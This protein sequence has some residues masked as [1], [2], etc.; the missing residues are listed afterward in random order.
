LARFD[1]DL[2]EF[3]LFR[4]SRGREG[5]PHGPPL[6]YADTITGRDGRPVRREWAVYPGPFGFGGAT[7]QVLLFDL[8]QLYAEQGGRGSQIQ[9]GTLRSLFMRRGE[10]NP[11]RKDYDRMRRDLDV[12]R[13]YDFHCKNAFWD[14]RR[15]AYVDMNWRLFGS[16]FYFRD[17][18]AGELPFGFIEVSPALQQVA[19]ERGFFS[20]GFP[21]QRFYALKP[22]EQRLAL[23]LAKKFA[24]QQVHRRF[25]EDLA[26]ALPVEAARP[27]DARAALKAAAE[28]LLAHGMPF[29]LSFRFEPSRDGRWLAV[30]TRR[31][32]PRRARPAPPAAEP[33][34]EAVAAQVERIIEATGCA[35]DRAW[36]SQCVRRLGAGPVDRGLGQLR[37][38][39]QSVHVRN[40]GGLLTKIFKDLA[41]EA[42]IALR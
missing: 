27:R 38:A 36:W 37:E 15:Q 18:R 5:A 29:L 7:T 10:R 11:S 16:V 2:A 24:S 25:A 6:T 13:G 1:A 14:R 19:R 32:A 3:P 42:G 12:L 22:L 8:V 34:E 30:F 9:F 40:P 39:R 17:K 35:G 4:F 28:G 31:E 21:R 23:Y 33:L 20:L 26:R 41:A